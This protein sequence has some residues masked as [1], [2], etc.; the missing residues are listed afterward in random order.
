MASLSPEKEPKRKS[1]FSHL[2]LALT[3]VVGASLAAL[4][5]NVF[6]LLTFRIYYSNYL[7][8]TFPELEKI[9]LLRNETQFLSTTIP[10]LH[11]YRSNENL[12]KTARKLNTTI[13]TSLRIVKDLSTPKEE[14]QQ[15]IQT[16]KDIQ[17]LN[18]KQHQ[19]SEKIINIEKKTQEMSEYFQKKIKNIFIAVDEE[20]LN[21]ADKS[22]TIESK[23]KKNLTTIALEQYM[24]LK[25]E[26]DE[27]T[28]IV[29]GLDNLTITVSLITSINDKIEI[30]K[31]RENFLSSIRGISSQAASIQDKKSKKLISEKIYNIYTSA[32]QEENP[33]S[34]KTTA[35]TLKQ[36]TQKNAIVILKKIDKLNRLSNTIY[37]EINQNNSELMRGYASTLTFGFTYSI[38][39]LLLLSW[40]YWHTYVYI[41][42]KKISHPLSE[43]TSAIAN[44]GR[45]IRVNTQFDTS[46]QELSDIKN[47]IKVF[48]HN[49]Q[50]LLSQEEKL[51]AQNR[52]LSESNDKLQTFTRVSSHDLKSPLRGIQLLCD[53]IDESINEK[54]LGAAKS[55]L[56]KM[57]TR[58]SRMDKLLDSLLQYTKSTTIS[59]GIKIEN[60]RSFIFIQYELLNLSSSYRLQINCDIEEITIQETELSLVIR[61]LLDNAIKHHDQNQGT[62]EITTTIEDSQLKIV[63]TDDGPGIP[64]AYQHR[65][66]EPFETLQPKDKVEG[67]GMGLSLVI[68]VV[69]S[70]GGS[71][72]LQSPVN[73]NRG[74]RF[75]VFWPLTNAI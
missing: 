18:K 64:K 14:K 56:A 12:K 46:T 11:L 8:K 31:Q 37:K 21:T 67:S 25:H 73:E 33:F 40:V 75:I 5:I 34:L 19:T 22:L 69:S 4:A 1:I 49:A 66:F 42:K 62:F 50:V 27:Y 59:K 38:L 16:L 28:N 45:N 26:L 7:N 20:I 9:S 32:T 44:I 72:E 39:S 47:S 2:N 13:Q 63:I 15:F 30:E 10:N 58:I 74:S 6:L 60:F 61:N 3:L 23:L 70:I 36:S 43:A 52:E 48:L 35:L 54:N 41:I 24:D 53:M 57:K 29:Y 17:Q 68:K 51:K 55:D 65:V 71:V